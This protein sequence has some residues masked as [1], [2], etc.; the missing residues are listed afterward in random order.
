[1]WTNVDLTEKRQA[2]PRDPDVLVNGGAHEG[3][4]IGEIDLPVGRT[5]GKQ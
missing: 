3:V 5:V 4:T 2:S 1:M